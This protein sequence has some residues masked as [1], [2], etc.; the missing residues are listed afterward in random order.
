MDLCVSVC[1]CLT[2]V[3]AQ[4][5]ADMSVCLS[6]HRDY[7]D[8]ALAGIG[9]LRNRVYVTVTYVFLHCCHVPTGRR[10][11]THTY[12]YIS[13][14]LI[15]FST[16]LLSRSRVFGENTFNH[17]RQKRQRPGVETLVTLPRM[18]SGPLSW[19]LFHM[20]NPISPIVTLWLSYHV[21]HVPHGPL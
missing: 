20:V 15:L 14:F 16:L 21:C 12:L 18:I 5:H 8:P 10:T 9:K 11:H 17:S 3:C 7:F 19:E 1:A 6:T 4:A 13:I 2:K